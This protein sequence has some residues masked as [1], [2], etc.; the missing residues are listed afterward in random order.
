LPL[1]RLTASAKVSEYG[2]YGCEWPLVALFARTRPPGT[3]IPD[4]EPW[5]AMPVFAT[6]PLR[7]STSLEKSTPL[8]VGARPSIS[9]GAAL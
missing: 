5:P 7:L 2:S 1:T 4:D 9:V 3:A 8:T 6:E